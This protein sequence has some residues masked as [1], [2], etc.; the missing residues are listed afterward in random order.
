MRICLPG[1]ADSFEQAVRKRMLFAQR[2]AHEWTHAPGLPPYCRDLPASEAFTAEKN[3]WMAIDLVE[4]VADYLLALV[5]RIG[6]RNASVASFRRYYPL[7]PIPSVASRW[8]Q[9]EEFAR[10]RLD[11]INPYLLKLATELPEHFPVTD[12]TLRGV[13]PEGSRLAT[14]LAERRLFLLDYALLHGLVPVLGRFCVAPIALF[15]R[16][17]AGQ[18]MPLAIQLGQSPAEAPVIFTPRDERWT[19]L[20]ARS[21]VQCADGAYHEVV[22][23]L[24]RTHL[25][26]EPVW[27]AAARTLPEQHPLY[28]LL[29]PHFTGT[30]DINHMARGS[31]LAPGGP[32]DETIAIGAEGSLT[33]VGMAYD[34]WT[35]DDTDPVADLRRRGLD[36]AEVLPHYHYRDDALALYGAIRDFVEGVLRAYYRD[37]ADVQSDPELQAWAQELESR[38][39][40]RIRRLPLV[41]GRFQRIEDLH[42]VV[43]RFIFNASVEHAAVNNGQYDQFGWIP[44]TPGSMYLPPPRDHTVNDEASFVYA[45]PDGLGVGEQLA[46]VHLLSKRTTKPLGTYD[47]DFL[48]DNLAARGALDRFRAR[49]DDIGRAIVERNRGLKVPYLYL[50]PWRVARSIAI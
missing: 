40:A 7:R 19:W 21:F 38:D 23:H 18:L 6:H 12:D 13:L 32:I 35:F 5:A 43:S 34:E 11:G 29:R 50:Q 9:D 42:E 20:M 28:Q 15:W 8:M 30:L 17:G 26:M 31:L 1:A 45:L 33:L 49:L 44:N 46:L 39:G 37:D 10:Q 47:E 41:D 25:V 2:Q 36:S 4:S 16:D 14:L 3:R 22:A 27:V 48:V 24:Q